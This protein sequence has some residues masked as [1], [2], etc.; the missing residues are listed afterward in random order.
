MSKTTPGPWT[1]I[2]EDVFHGE[3][4]DRNKVC[5]ARYGK[6]DAALIAAA[7]DLLKWATEYTSNAKP[8][9]SAAD[10]ATRMDNAFNELRA[11]IAKAGG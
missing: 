5:T 6:K 2:D 3:T 10:Y 11:A 7:P 1:A 8:G 9:E 4:K